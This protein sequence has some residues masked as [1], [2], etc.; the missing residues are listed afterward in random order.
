[1]ELINDNKELK[2]EVEEGRDAMRRLMEQVSSNRGNS[3]STH[4]HTIEKEIDDYLHHNPTCKGVKL[5]ILPCEEFNDG[6]YDGGY[7]CW[8]DGIE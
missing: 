1:M 8:D 6:L 5:F 7:I 3:S 2:A 4:T